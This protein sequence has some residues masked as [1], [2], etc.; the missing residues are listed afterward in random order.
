MKESERR[1]NYWNEADHIGLQLNENVNQWG[2]G[3]KH[4]EGVP[5]KRKGANANKK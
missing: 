3:S 2:P 5:E 1:S 4:F